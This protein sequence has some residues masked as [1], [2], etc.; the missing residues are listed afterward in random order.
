M[1]KSVN[2]YTEKSGL[3]NLNLIVVAFLLLLSSVLSAAKLSTNDAQQFALSFFKKI[4]AQTNSTLKKAPTTL[5]SVQL[6]YASKENVSMPVCVFQ[7]SQH[8]FVV[9]AQCSKGFEVIGYSDKSTFDAQNIPS[10]FMGLLRVYEQADPEKIIGLNVENESKAIV[11]PLL[12]KAGVQLNQYHHENVGGSWT[13]CVATAMTQ[14]LCYYKTPSKGIGSHCFQSA[15]GQLCA[16]F[17][18]TTYNW[19]NP[20]DDDYKKLSYHV[21]VAMDMNYSVA[22]SSPSAADYIYTLDKYFGCFTEVI[23]TDTE[24]ILEALNL[25]KP[26]YA[27]VPGNPGHAV[28]ID[29]YDSNLYL[30]LNFGW[31]GAAN[32][33][34]L[35]NTNSMMEGLHFGT[36]ISNAAVVSNKPVYLNKTDSLALVSLKNN[37]S[38]INWDLSNSQK[39]VGITTLN[40]NVISLYI[41]SPNT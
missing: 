37:I 38:G 6:Q 15:F 28:V 41:N 1:K 19:T 23:P 27:T 13:G 35:M 29:G 34:Y 8:G 10:N 25:L 4:S 39:R 14:I 17:G 36:N 11:E 9:L 40:G 24:Y 18:A 32:G 26:L 5:Q 12:D 7:S 22:G 16:D 31:G 33:Y 30:H 3:I 20:T 2:N 21:G